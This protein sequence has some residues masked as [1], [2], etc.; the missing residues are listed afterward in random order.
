M[1]ITVTVFWNW[2]DFFIGQWGAI[3]MQ[4]DPYTQNVRGM[5]RLVV[6]SYWDMG[7]IREESFA[8]AKLK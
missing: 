5:I 1:N 2:D 3:D 4:V 6:N 8:A 7:V